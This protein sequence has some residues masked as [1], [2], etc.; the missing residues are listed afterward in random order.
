MVYDLAYSF[1]M[2]LILGGIS[3]IPLMP[4]LTFLLAIVSVVLSLIL[5]IL[6]SIT[7]VSFCRLIPCPHKGVGSGITIAAKVF[8]TL[9]VACLTFATL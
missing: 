4:E 3:A 9:L 8:R 1:L 5:F 2:L 7:R 6:S